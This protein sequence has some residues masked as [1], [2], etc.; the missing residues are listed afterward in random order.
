MK[1]NID[2]I[3]INFLSTNLLMYVFFSISFL[4]LH[5]RQVV[6]FLMMQEV[7]TPWAHLTALYF[8]L[9][10]TV[11]HYI[12]RALFVS[13]LPGYHI[14]QLGNRKEKKRKALSSA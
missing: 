13:T 2:V 3:P 8:L 6:F 10:Y 14:S 7:V 4:F 12:H 9:F 1:G 5:L 11:L